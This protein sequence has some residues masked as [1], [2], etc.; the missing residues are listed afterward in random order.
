MTSTKPESASM[1][2]EEIA[3]NLND[4]GIPPRFGDENSRLLIKMWRILGQGRPVTQEMTVTA[5][6]EVGMSSKAAGEFLR[7]IT[8][9]DSDD[10]IIGLLGLSLNQEWAHRLTINGAA[11]RTWCAWDTLFLPAMLGETVQIESESPVSG[12]TIRL[13]VTPDEVESSSPEGAVVSIATI[14]PK[15][16]DMSTV[17]AIW[18]N[19]CHQVFFFP[20]L[21]EASEWAEGKTNIAILPVRDAYE[22]G[23]L[24]FADLRRYAR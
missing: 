6:K 13:A 18:G 14:D 9:R 16:H 19:F 21:E 1:S 4:A 20:S 7:Q 23:R 15:I 12:T 10:N 5:A 8:E 3:K 11:F 24:A 2:I 22:L 17:E